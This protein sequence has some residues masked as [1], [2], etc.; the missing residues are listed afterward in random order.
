MAVAIAIR[1]DG[2][3]GAREH[4]PVPGS[5]LLRRSGEPV[6]ENAGRESRGG[7]NGCTPEIRSGVAARCMFRGDPE[8]DHER[9]TD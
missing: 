8:P 2:A 5:E 3:P 9:S 4:G 1:V 7:W 6:V